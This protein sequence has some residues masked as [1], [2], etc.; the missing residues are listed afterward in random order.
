MIEGFKHRIQKR[1]PVITLTVKD[2]P[3]GPQKFILSR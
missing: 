2:F 3:F 1:L